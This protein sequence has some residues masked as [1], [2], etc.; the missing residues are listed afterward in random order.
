MK[1]VYAALASGLMLV[2]L[3]PSVVSADR[4]ES[5]SDHFVFASCDA[6]IDGGFV[7]VSVESS[8]EGEFRFMGVSIW[9]DPDEPVRDR[10]HRGRVDRHRRPDR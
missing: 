4:P 8:T 6:P 7:S 9:L 10:P 3:L 5:S 1:R 2:A